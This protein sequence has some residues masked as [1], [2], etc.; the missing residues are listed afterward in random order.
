MPTPRPHTIEVPEATLSDLKTRLER[1]RWPDRELVSDWTQGIPLSYV[2]DIC[3]Y[4]LNIY[5]WRK[6]EE[7][8]N[9]HDNFLI[10]IDGVDIH[11]LVK[12]S[13]AI[14]SRPLL[15][16]HGWPGSI[17]EFLNL[18][19]LLVQPQQEGDEPFDVVTPSLPGF[20]FSGKPREVGWGVDKIADAWVELM[21]SL[22]YSKFLV[23]GGDWG[24]AVSG[25]IAANHSD[26]CLGIH[27]NMPSVG[28]RRD[29][30]D[31]LTP[32]EEEALRGSRFY[33]D[34]DSGY[35]KQQSTRPQ[36]LGYGLVD[37]PAAQAAWIL[38][39]FYQWTDCDG[40]PENAISR[41]ELI[42]NIMMYW[43][44][45]SGTSSARIYWESFGR[46]SRKDIEVPSGCSIFPKEIF[47][48]SKRWVEVVYKDLRYYNVL[49]KGGH[50]AAFENPVQFALELRAC[51][52]KM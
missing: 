44:S 23:Q 41:D 29:T 21:G 46:G 28:P 17:I 18:I 2:Q 34:W 19:D 48:P 3:S 7:R 52:G 15:I 40:H 8:L 11:F 45:A 1:T 6:T 24:A 27:T 38:E 33:Q 32:Q 42:D 31:D 47:K 36:T 37:S 14:K 12:K 5:D 26:S 13:P 10:T 9:S 50:F 20:G 22:G 30:L 4:W 49:E 35:S 16:T 25:S 39:K 43:L 51:F